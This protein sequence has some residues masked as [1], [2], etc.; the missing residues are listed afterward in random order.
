[1]VCAC[2]VCLL[3]VPHLYSKGTTMVNRSANAGPAELTASS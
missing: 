2:A 1:M 3:C